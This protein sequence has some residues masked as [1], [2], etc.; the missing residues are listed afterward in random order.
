MESME[1]KSQGAP[2]RYAVAAKASVVSFSQGNVHFKSQPQDVG[3]M[4]PED[5]SAMGSQS[6]TC[7]GVKG[8]QS[9][10]NHGLNRENRTEVRTLYWKHVGNSTSLREPR[11]WN[12]FV[13]RCDECGF[14][15]DWRQKCHLAERITS[16]S[17][18]S[19]RIALGQDDKTESESKNSEVKQI[20][21]GHQTAICNETP[22]SNAE[23]SENTSQEVGGSSAAMTDSNKEH[24]RFLRKL[25]QFCGERHHGLK[26]CSGQIVYNECLICG[27]RHHWKKKCFTLDFNSSSSQSR[28]GNAFPTSSSQEGNYASVMHSIVHADGHIVSQQGRQDSHVKR[29]Y[30]VKKIC[31]LCGQKHHHRRKCEGPARLTAMH[32]DAGATSDEQ[33]TDQVTM[34]LLVACCLTVC[35]VNVDVLRMIQEIRQEERMAIAEVERQAK[36]HREQIHSDAMRLIGQLRGRIAK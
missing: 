36:L 21:Q 33:G 2:L 20:Q 3:T 28:P 34:E 17:A 19:Q 35:Q 32:A 23:G 24:P 8:E 26:N 4:L 22:R 5:D 7:S 6:T 27:E 15:H 9:L 10:S 14:L 16:T 30:Q 29:K 18:S 31:D 1:G 25:C 11:G 13:C 12:E